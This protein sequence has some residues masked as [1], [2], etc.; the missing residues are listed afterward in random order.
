[1]LAYNSWIINK[2]EIPNKIDFAAAIPKT[3]I[4]KIDKKRIRVEFKKIIQDNY[5]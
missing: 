2:W 4:G 5:Q 3:L 1:L